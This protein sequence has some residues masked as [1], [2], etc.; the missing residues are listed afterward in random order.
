MI[1]RR[2]VLAFSFFPAFVPPDNGGVERLYNFYSELSHHHDVTLISSSFMGGHRE[3]IQHRPSFTEVRIPKDAHFADAYAELSKMSG[4]GD[5]SGPALGKASEHFGGMHDEYLALYPQADLIIHDSP[6]LI[7]CDL[8]RGFDSKVRIYN[9]YNCETDLYSSFH[10]RDPQST[11][12][13]ELVR[14]L[15]QELC[16]YCDLIT[17]CSEED[18]AL[19]RQHFDPTAPLTI[20]PN[21]FTP[22]S[23]LTEDDREPRSVVFLGSAHQPNVDAARLIVENIAPK[24]PDV[25]FHL[26]G[27]CHAVGK[28][29]NVIAHGIISQ[30]AKEALLRR[31]SAAINPMTSG[32]GS[33]LKIADI[34][35]NGCPLLSTELGVRGFNLEPNVH[36]ISLDADNAVNTIRD[37]L[38]DGDLRARVAKRALSHFEGHYSWREIVASFVGRM[39]SLTSQAVMA[40]KARL[41]LNDYDSLD[42]TG[43]GA[44]RTRGLC[45]GLAETSQIIFLAF[46]NDQKPRRRVSE[47]GRILS[48][49]VDKL[50][51]HLAEHELHN[52]LH[53]VSTADIVSYRH[54]AQNSR[55][56]ALFRC[57]AS[58]SAAIICE[59]PYM[60]GLPRAYGV[61]FIYSSQN[62]EIALKSEGLRDHP[63]R[64]QL[65]PLVREAESFACSASTFIVAVS[66]GDATSLGATYRSTAPIMVVPNGAEGPAIGE[67]GEAAPGPE[68]GRPVAIFIGSVH[69]PNYEA[70]RW[71][72]TDLATALPQF[73]F[74]FVG[75]IASSLTGPMPSNVKLIGEVSSIEKTRHLGEARVALNPM[76]SGSGSNV[77]MADYLQHGVPV[78]TTAFGARGY[79]WVPSTDALVTELEAFRD[80]LCNLMQSKTS[81]EQ[82]REAR[83]ANYASKLSM[84]AGG[85]RLAQLIDE[86]GGARK[87]AL[88]VTYRYNDPARGGGEEYVVRLVHALAASGWEVDV[89]SPAADRIVDVN[90]FSAAFSGPEMQPIPTDLA[91][92]RSIK[93]PLDAT[94]PSDAELR[95]LWKFQPDFE[96]QVAKLLTPPARSCLAWGWADPE[97]EGRWCFTSAGLHMAEGSTLR[98]RARALAPVW[99]QIFSQDGRRLHSLESAPDVDVSC[100][101]PAGYIS[102]RISMKEAVTLDDPRPLALFVAELAIKERSLLHDRVGDQW[103]EAN[104]TTARMAA[105]AAAR[106]SVR[107]P[108][109][110]EL[111]RLRSP[112]N[113]LEKHVRDHVSKYDLLITHNAVFGGTTAAVEAAEASRVPSILIPHLHYDDDF[114]HFRDVIAACA[115][116]SVTL[117]SPLGV[118]QLLEEQGFA[119]VAYH[120][121]GVDVSAAFT[122]EDRE[123]FNNVLPGPL[124]SFFLVLGR[125][126]PAKR[127]HDVIDA[128]GEIAPELA[129]MIVMIGPD[130]DGVPIDNPRV[131]YLGRQPDAVVRGALRECQGL[132]NMSRSESFGMVLLEAGLAGKPVLANRDC[133][134]FAD[135]VQDGVNGFLTTRDELP[136]RMLELL[137][138]QALR[139][140]LGQKGRELA[141]QRDWRNAEDDFVRTCG[142]L[143]ETA[144]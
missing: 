21:G 51:Q 141:L 23:P 98:L 4:A 42:S 11:V 116:A 61:E 57:A 10:S 62:I 15:E 45:R 60:V 46:A 78:L 130:D 101:V 7:N 110:L 5:L 129:P 121:P 93:F 140:Q 114:Y 108:H 84:D 86:H 99:I 29:R 107:D 65:L 74:A 17:V 90:R 144:S 139:H 37:S 132:I 113:S 38:A 30:K 47:D 39:E 128:V 25:T 59:H 50:P 63:L 67:N 13:A 19:F 14:S 91:R 135:L 55:L 87:R 124:R 112:S 9:S 22:G 89:V 48:L 44:T 8:F 92:V 24:I 122:N 40:P 70:A 94:A 2:H 36:Y 73:D 6:F 105:L 143:V 18:A 76:M 133:A 79:E 97:A 64:E 34:G 58:C 81:S 52:S 12:I 49:L 103:A 88:Y 118:K 142:S 136:T 96:E 54:A 1:N 3:V 68:G 95:S 33:S 72:A 83:K 117:V 69:G 100:D 111:S 71:I 109:A 131:I 28:A 80:E 77:K 27:S 20:V 41:V 43:G 123:A 75:S 16:R 26:I 102:F 85:Q 115:K 104:S 53:W 119:N 125:K 56:M 137:S 66:K 127:Y 82:A 138:D 106:T 32:G 35:S 126:A 120:G 31:A 134:A